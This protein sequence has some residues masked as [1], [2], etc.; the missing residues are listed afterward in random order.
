MYADKAV[1][2]VLDV[3]IFENKETIK[4][5]KLLTLTSLNNLIP[6]SAADWLTG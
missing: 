6:C 4:W 2:D 1:N 5:I 3:F